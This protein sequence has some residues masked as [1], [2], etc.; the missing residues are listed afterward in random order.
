MRR[1]AAPGAGRGRW[2]RSG[3]RA[4]ATGCRVALLLWAATLLLGARAA[5]EDDRCLLAAVPDGDVPLFAPKEDAPARLRCPIQRDCTEFS[6]LVNWSGYTPLLHCGV[7]RVCGRKWEDVRVEGRP[8]LAPYGRLRPAED[9]DELLDVPPVAAAYQPELCAELVVKRGWADFFE[10]EHAIGPKSRVTGHT[11]LR[12]GTVIGACR[13]HGGFAQAY[14]GGTPGLII[15]NDFDPTCRR[16]D[17]SYF[18]SDEDTCFQPIWRGVTTRTTWV[19]LERPDGIERS[20]AFVRPDTEVIVEGLYRGRKGGT[21][22]RIDAGAIRGLVPGAALDVGGGVEARLPVRAVHACPE[23]APILETECPVVAEV[24]ERT[25]STPEGAMPKTVTLRRGVQLLDL[26]EAEG[27]RTVLFLDL[28]LT[29]RGDRCLSDTGR[30]LALR[31]PRASRL[32]A[33]GSTACRVEEEVRRHGE[34]TFGDDWEESISASAR[35]L[36]FWAKRAGIRPADLVLSPPVPL[37]LASPSAADLVAVA[38]VSESRVLLRAVVAGRKS[39]FSAVETALWPDFEDSLGVVEEAPPGPG[40]AAPRPRPG[41]ADGDLD[42]LLPRRLLQEHRDALLGLAT[43][44]ATP[45]SDTTAACALL[46][47]G[48]PAVSREIFLDVLA[49]VPQG[50]LV[51]SALAGYGEAAAESAPGSRAARI[52]TRTCLR[53]LAHPTHQA[54]CW[55]AADAGVYW[56]QIDVIGPA[57]QRIRRLR[58]RNGQ[59]EGVLAAVAA[60]EGDIEGASAHWARALDEA[61][62]SCGPDSRR[63]ETLGLQL[64]RSTIET[65][66]WDVSL[67]LASHLPASVT[68]GNPLEALT[69]F[70]ESGRVSAARTLLDA[71]DQAAGGT[72]VQPEVFLWGAQTMD[73][74]CRFERAAEHAARA[75]QAVGALG[76]FLAAAGPLEA[77]PADARSAMAVVDRALLAVPEEWHPMIDR[78]LP[79]RCASPCAEWLGTEREAAQLLALAEAGTLSLSSPYQQRVDALVESAGGACAASLRE[80]LVDLTARRSWM[81]ER[82]GEFAADHISDLQTEA[83]LNAEIVAEL[84]Q[85]VRRHLEADRAAHAAGRFDRWPELLARVPIPSSLVATASRALTKA[86]APDVDLLPC[87]LS[88]ASAAVSDVDA[89]GWV[90]RTAASALACLREAAD[91]HDLADLPRTGTS[92]RAAPAALRYLPIVALVHPDVLDPATLEDL[93][94][95]LARRIEQWAEANAVEPSSRCVVHRAQ[96]LSVLGQE[97]PSDEP[98]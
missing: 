39:A 69:L 29:L 68:C 77:L 1:P 35:T 59:D 41:G 11:R 34:Q 58:P 84:D 18:R 83:Q 38:N 78:V 9:R 82:L 91:D 56:G 43:D 16:V 73:R 7:R 89:A 3:R 15:P 63:V 37:P 66:E 67:W 6:L 25:S 31:R 48:F 60:A 86:G 27:R 40:A 8:F 61:W 14:H 5:R 54:A 42:R 79:L 22:Y 32:A 72:A 90:D 49:A 92:K 51:D 64:L 33:V 80:A 94:A 30:R 95:P 2:I 98:E 57:V 36:V 50:P 62:R 28:V 97:P 88:G 12:P 17:E 53:D 47:L 44:S 52:L 26:G 81:Q 65:E 19:Y 74:L 24:S 23:A 96:T 13:L 21:W 93:P 75:E 46:A 71:I 76:A 45:A 4:R 70:G 20:D 87:V 55:H 10:L 85:L